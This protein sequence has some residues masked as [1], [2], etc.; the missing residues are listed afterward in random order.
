MKKRLPG[1]LALAVFF[2]FGWSQSHGQQFPN[3]WTT[4]FTDGGAGIEGLTGDD[5]G[6]LYLADRLA[7]TCRVWEIK[8]KMAGSSVK[9]VGAVNAAGCRPSGITFGPDGALYITS[10][11]QIY[12][13]EPHPS[14]PSATLYA[15]NVPGANG[16]AFLGNDLFVSDGTQN[17]GRIWKIEPCE[18][19][20]CAAVEFLRIQPRRNS[21]DLGGNVIAED[22]LDGV[23]TVRYTVPRH[24]T[25]SP[26]VTDRQDIVVNGIAFSADGTKMFVADTARGAIWAA[27]LDED[28]NL[29]SQQGCDETFHENVL[30]IS[31]PFARR[32]RWHRSAPRWD[33][34]GVRKRAECHR[35][36]R[37]R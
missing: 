8:L 5:N 36:C 19:P 7:N 27:D 12:R 16:V 29:T 26:G 6:K 37:A 31:T 2:G 22:Q 10:P 21:E 35:G 1:A 34:S 24:D 23:G 14:V 3:A 32:C 11:S 9:Q 33:H 4:V 30:C 25:G 15:E 13:L 17:Q 28:G 20:P 18:S